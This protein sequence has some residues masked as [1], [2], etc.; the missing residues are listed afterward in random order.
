MLT[1][2]I[3]GRENEDGSGSGSRDQSRVDISGFPILQDFVFNAAT[4][5]GLG[6]PAI[7]G[8]GALAQDTV[9]IPSSGLVF[10]NSYGAGVTNVF[11]NA[12]VAA[13][14]Y[15]ENHFT[16]SITIHASFD[17]KRS[18]RRSAARTP[19]AA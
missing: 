15:L 1:D 6:A 5:G 7:D 11:H 8:T 2:E 17:L 12:I 19:S 9:T 13:E 10:V 4:G 14:T 16:N 18:I 3:L